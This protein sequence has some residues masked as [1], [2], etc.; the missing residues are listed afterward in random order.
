MIAS[1]RL[2]RYQSGRLVYGKKATQGQIA[3]MAGIDPH[4]LRNIESG[5]AV[6]RLSTFEAILAALDVYI[7]IPIST[8]QAILET[9]GLKKD[10]R[11]VVRNL[12]EAAVVQGAMQIW[13]KK[14]GTASFLPPAPAILSDIGHR[15][16]DFNPIFVAGVGL[17]ADHPQM[18]EL[19][20]QTLYDL[21]FGFMP[22]ILGG[23]FL[24]N[25]DESLPAIVTAWK[26]E[27]WPYRQQDWYWSRVEEARQRYPEFRRLW[28]SIP[29]SPP[30]FPP[31]GNPTRLV[32]RTR[33]SGKLLSFGVISIAVAN[34]DRLR[35]VQLVPL[36]QL[37]R[38]HFE[39]M[40]ISQEE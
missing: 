26:N 25:G 12:P 7:P 5:K 34:D 11:V 1:L 21:I 30:P 10:E 29:D 2:Q 4:S 38:L 35:I 9:Y 17:L 36:D 19:R 24:V 3:G 32:V 40:T 33:Q 14:T 6:P 39:L 15:I 22:G 20:S 31:T 16:L 37:S 8:R 18:A 28:D 23:Q 13:K 27:L